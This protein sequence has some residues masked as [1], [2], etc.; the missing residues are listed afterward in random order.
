MLRTKLEIQQESGGFY[1]LSDTKSCAF[2]KMIAL[3]INTESSLFLYPTPL[4]YF[5][6]FYKDNI[7]AISMLS[8]A[9]DVSYSFSDESLYLKNRQFKPPM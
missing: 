1:D 3:F 4:F 7:K 9:F 8:M 6:N 2:W 5:F